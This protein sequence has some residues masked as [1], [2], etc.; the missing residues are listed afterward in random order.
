MTH[1]WV[2]IVFGVTTILIFATCGL[3]LFGLLLM[4]D[5]DR[6]GDLVYFHQTVEDGDIIFISNYSNDTG[7]FSGFNEYGII[8]KSWGKVY[9]WDKHNSIKQHLYDWV[10]TSSRVR[11]Y[12]IKV[13]DFFISD[14]RSNQEN[15]QSLM[16]SDSLKFIIENY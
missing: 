5:E 6:Y 11:V 9:V 1:R 7:Q 8:E 2:K 16:N 15:Y 10:G 3:I 13:S 4:E 14:I 12:R